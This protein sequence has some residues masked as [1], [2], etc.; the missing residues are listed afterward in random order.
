CTP[1]AGQG[2]LGVQCRVDDVESRSLLA[3]IDDR[4]VRA[5]VLAERAF[6]KQLG[7]G[8]EIPAGAIARTLD[9][10]HLD[11]LGVVASLDGRR[12]ARERQAGPLDDPA[13]VGQDLADRL[14]PLARELLRGASSPPRPLDGLPWGP[15]AAPDPHGRLPWGPSAAPDP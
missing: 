14:L 4:L 11:L 8:C 12:W 2:V 9:D 5:E 13:R 7:G 10:Q 1:A 6:L 3:A 15:S